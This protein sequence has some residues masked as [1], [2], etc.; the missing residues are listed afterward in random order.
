M[1]VVSSSFATDLEAERLCELLIHTQSKT[2][3]DPDVNI[4]APIL[5]S[6]NVPAEHGAKMLCQVEIG[7]FP[8]T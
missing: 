5:N 4:L 6:Y 1:V 2:G 8:R 7:L 3:N